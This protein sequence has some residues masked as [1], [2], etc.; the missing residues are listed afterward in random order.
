MYDLISCCYVLFILLWKIFGG[1]DRLK[2]FLVIFEL[3]CVS[4]KNAPYITTHFK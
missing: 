4:V 2:A 1:A 3:V